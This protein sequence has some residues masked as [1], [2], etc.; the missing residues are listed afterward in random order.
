MNEVVLGRYVV[1]TINISE[2]K[3][4]GLERFPPDILLEICSLLEWE[5]ILR[6]RRVC[7][8]VKEVVNCSPKLRPH[9]ELDIFASKH[10]L[11]LEPG[12]RFFTH[13]EMHRGKLVCEEALFWMA[14]LERLTIYGEGWGPHAFSRVD[15]VLGILEKSIPQTHFRLIIDIPGLLNGFDKEVKRLF[16]RI[17]SSGLRFKATV[18]GSMP[19]KRVSKSPISLLKRH[20]LSLVLQFNNVEKLMPE[21]CAAH[22]DKA[23]KI[24]GGQE[25]ASISQ[26]LTFLQ[27]SG[28]VTKCEFFEFTFFGEA[29]ETSLSNIEAVSFRKCRC[30]SAPSKSLIKLLSSGF[31]NCQVLMATRRDDEILLEAA[32][33]SITLKQWSVADFLNLR[34]NLIPHETILVGFH[35]IV[36]NDLAKATKPVRLDDC[37]LQRSKTDIV[38]LATVLSTIKL[39]PSDIYPSQSPSLD[40]ATA[41]NNIILLGWNI[42]EYLAVNL[43]ANTTELNLTLLSFNSAFLDV[44]T[45]AARQGRK[46]RVSY[47]QV[48]NDKGDCPVT[49]VKRF[50]GVVWGV[51]KR[52]N[53]A[54]NPA[55]TIIEDTLELVGWSPMD[56][57]QVFL[58]GNA[59]TFTCLSVSCRVL[60]MFH[61]SV[62][63]KECQVDRDSD[64]CKVDIVRLL[65]TLFSGSTSRL[66]ATIFFNSVTLA[67]DRNHL[68]F[69]DCN[70]LSLFCALNRTNISLTYAKFHLPFFSW[71]L[72]GLIQQAFKNNPFLFSTISKPKSALTIY[73]LYIV[74]DLPFLTD[75]E[76]YISNEKAIVTLLPNATLDLYYWSPAEILGLFNV[77]FGPNLKILLE[78]LYLSVEILEALEALKTVKLLHATLYGSK[79]KKTMAQECIS[80]RVHQCIISLTRTGLEKVFVTGKDL[81]TIDKPLTA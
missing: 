17:D 74:A 12:K 50:C 66:T 40:L 34:E 38:S 15:R 59:V 60:N 45:M 27:N 33:D 3:N 22:S 4:M 28:N 55:S 68:T 23:L 13:Y 32:D 44:A 36:S 47:C 70:P 8:S 64:S 67:S 51:G 26:V 7:S 41:K 18:C 62:K 58:P 1:A 31:H 30:T 35:D 39:Q 76:I 29:D 73:D 78:D 69:V 52:L 79:L 56:V 72:S 77:H 75:A 48:F 46:L 5:D 9:L 49:K 25:K 57:A 11:C 43:K 71:P 20:P 53:V 54:I 61:T 14:H 63:V 16:R 2:G 80:K 65:T 37:T 10:Y 81:P 24:N 6:L 19:S 21:F 42:E